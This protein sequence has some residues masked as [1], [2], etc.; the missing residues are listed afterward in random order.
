MHG[1]LP[2]QVI[3]W[4]WLATADQRCTKPVTVTAGCTPLCIWLLLVTAANTHA[5]TARLIP[6]QRTTRSYCRHLFTDTAALSI[7]PVLQAISAR[8][9]KISTQLRCPPLL[10]F[11]LVY[12][13]T[14]RPAPY[15][16]PASNST[17]PQPLDSSIPGVASHTAG[18]FCPPPSSCK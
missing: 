15:T 2:K 10:C 13:S 7:A 9:A 4:S 16:T 11:L 17:L 1:Q 8:D 18:R 3:P 12:T 6:P 5:C 14:D